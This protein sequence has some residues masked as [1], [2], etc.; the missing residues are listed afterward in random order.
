MKYDSHWN[1]EEF[2]D[3][4]R[5]GQNTRIEDR[6][7][8][9]QKKKEKQLST[10]HHT[11]NHSA[12]NTNPTKKQGVN[13]CGQKGWAVPLIWFL[14]EGIRYISASTIKRVSLNV[15]LTMY[16]KIYS[17]DIIR[18]YKLFLSLG[19]MISFYLVNSINIKHI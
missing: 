17:S 4:K 9:S 5:G 3:T 14:L 6:Q 18:L 1:E 16:L 10:K 2:E 19:S 15:T 12:S 11:E 7:H 8:N 13:S